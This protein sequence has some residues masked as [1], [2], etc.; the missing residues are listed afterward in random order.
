V[1]VQFHTLSP[2]LKGGGVHALRFHDLHNGV[3]GEDIV[4]LVGVKGYLAF[5][6]DCAAFF[7]SREGVSTCFFK[8]LDIDGSCVIRH[9][10]F[11]NIFNIP[12]STAFNLAFLIGKD[13][14]PDDDVLNLTRDVADFVNFIPLDFV[15]LEGFCPLLQY[16][17]GFE[18]DGFKFLFIEFYCRRGRLRRR[19]GINSGDSVLELLALFFKLA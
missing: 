3:R 9:R 2:A 7:E 11:Y 16:R 19:R 4:I 14:A 6:E 17:E 18:V 8:E 12:R 1:K 13:V 5:E 10:H 15:T